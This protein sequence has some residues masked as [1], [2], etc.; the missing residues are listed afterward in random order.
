LSDNDA[1][2]LETYNGRK[3]LYTASVY[4]DYNDSLENNLKALEK[5]LE[6][7]KGEKVIISMDINSI[8]N[9]V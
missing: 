8:N 4:L 5:I 3:S 6:F 7:T 1:V 2:F 9:L